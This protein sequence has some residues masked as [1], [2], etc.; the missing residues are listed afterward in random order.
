MKRKV[1]VLE[2]ERKQSLMQ[3]APLEMKLDDMQRFTKASS[4]EIR[5]YP[6]RKNWKVKPNFARS[7]KT[8]VKLFG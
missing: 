8:R 6:C 7:Y 1:E 2:A 5:I 4:I 3:I